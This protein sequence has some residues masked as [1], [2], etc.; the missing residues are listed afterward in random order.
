MFVGYSLFEL[1][2]LEQPNSLKAKRSIVRRLCDRIR[3]RLKISV[4]EVG[5]QDVYQKAAL[6]VSA[7]SGDQETVKKLLRNAYDVIVAEGSA[8]VL[9]EEREV[10]SV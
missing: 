9:N 1:F 7:V 5:E 8:E 6:G 4:A 10:F 3:N 2:L